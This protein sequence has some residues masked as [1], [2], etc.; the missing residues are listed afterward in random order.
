MTE[1]QE[2]MLAETRRYQWNKDPKLKEATTSEEGQD[3]WQD[4]HGDPRA[5]DRREN[6]TSACGKHLKKYFRF[7][8]ATP[9]KRFT[10][11]NFLGL[12]S[13]N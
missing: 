13:V 5:G 4:L 6:S 7:T 1:V 11:K 3:I 9:A 8:S 2:E 12:P 10:T